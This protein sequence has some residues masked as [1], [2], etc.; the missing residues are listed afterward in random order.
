M[1]QNNALNKKS[2]HYEID[3]YVRQENAS[4]PD[5]SVWVGASAGSGKTKVLTD[6]VLR[7]LLPDKNGLN[8]VDPGQILALTFTKAAANEMAIRINEELGK[9]AI[10]PLDDEGKNKGLTSSLHS[11]LGQMPTLCQIKYAQQ[12]FAKVI[13]APGGLKIMTIHSFCTSI[14]GR[15]PLEAGLSPNFKAI[16]ESDSTPLLHL[17]INQV[18]HKSQDEKGSDLARAFYNLALIQNE[19]QIFELIKKMVSERRQIQKILDENFGA[20]GLY[21]SLCQFFDIDDTKSA[22]DIISKACL[23]Q[24]FDEHALR[25]ACK[26]LSLGSPAKDVGK[27]IIIQ[28]WLDSTHQQRVKSFKSYQSAF[29]KKD[30]DI[31]SPIAQKKIQEQFPSIEENLVNEATR[32]KTINEKLSSLQIAV[33]TRDLFL[34]GGE[35]LNYYAN[36]KKQKAYL[37]Y[38][39]L[40]LNT[41]DLLTGQTKA[42]KNIGDVSPWI[43]YKLDQGIDHVLV[44]EAQDTNPEQWDIIRALT[45]DFTNTLEGESNRTLFIVGDEKQSIYSFQ[46]AS[47]EKFEEMRQYFSNK[48]NENNK[49]FKQVPFI[50]SFRSTK[51]VLNFVDTVFGNEIYRQ[52]LGHDIIEHQSFRKQQPGLVTL[53]P[54]FKNPEKVEKDVW[55][56]PT[57][58]IDSTSGAQA[59][60]NYI[61]DQ[62]QRWLNDK[63][64]IL[65]S[66][67]RRIEAK[68]IMI[69][70]RTRNKFLD[71]L[72]RALKIRNIPVSGVDRMVLNDQLVV[73]D[74]CAA[75]QFAL[76]PDDDLTLAGL[77]KSPFIGMEEQTLF[78]LS[79]ARKKLSLW[80]RVR[81]SNHKDIIAW[82][83]NII[84]IGGK[85]SPY[86]FFSQILQFPCPKNNKSGL[87]AIKSRLG[88][89]VIDPI[90]EF[91]NLVLNYEQKTVHSMQEFLM[92]QESNLQQIKRELD[93]AGNMVRIMT[94]HGAKGLQSP[95]VILPDTIRATS[96]RKE[97]LLLPQKTLA[98][99]PYFCPTSSNLPTACASAMQ[100]LEDKETQEYRR[101]FYVAATRAESELYIAGNAGM[102]RSRKESWYDYAR[103]TFEILDDVQP[104]ICDVTGQEIFQYSN[105]ATTQKAD[106]AEK[107]SFVSTTKTDAPSWLYQ[108]IEHTQSPLKMLTPSRPEGIDKEQSLSPLSPSD[109]NRFKR[110]NI[111]HK[112]LQILPDVHRDFWE[113]KIQYFLSLPAHNLSKAEQENILIE[114]LKI[115]K[116]PVF[117]PIFGEGSRAEVSITAIVDNKTLSGQ[118]DRLLIARDE[119]L[120]V[121]YKTNRPP[122]KKAED[123]PLIYKNQMNAYAAALSQIYPDKKIKKA[124]IWTNTATLMVVP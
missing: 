80:D 29:L 75:A 26:A 89:E 27:S 90:D 84:A 24:N 23:V 85:E 66:Y 123:I 122:P 14:L 37:D 79:Y 94:I 52:G 54:L 25:D 86:N 74:L 103:D 112:L 59:L 68:D 102:E 32:L 93:D 83:E 47:P 98:P 6:R 21:T 81:Q 34:F 115:L 113:E 106:K 1:I 50:T 2:I 8:A 124:L 100:Y 104:Q 20:I 12:L 38:D 96:N 70:L 92:L 91:I 49:E 46:R 36:L 64:R 108:K 10:L 7:L 82:L 116:D 105:P 60:A 40:I 9:W 33:L 41:L 61:G 76:L 58:I 35:I 17:A 57:Q 110:G 107:D 13:D 30:G 99:F 109:N 44:D 88:D 87:A 43:R 39:D 55:T 5:Y 95:V 4:N 71:Q 78:D 77:L 62:I 69:L 97:R 119:I 73:Q 18:I 118:I 56:A 48:F 120:I 121:D 63:D 67:G 117:A 53:W 22:D 19:E 15:F 65:H 72:V 114:T 31:F 42:L 28:T 11:L 3:P 16:E 51:A 111:I 45:D 101:L